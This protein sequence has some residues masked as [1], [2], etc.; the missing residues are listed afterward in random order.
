MD[1][2]RLTPAAVELVVVDP[3]HEHAAWCLARYTEEL[4]RRSA[5]TFDPSTGATALPEEL[6]PPAG[7]FFVAYV[8]GEPVGCGAVKHHRDAP[9]EI[10]RMW[11]AP[12]ARG[13][14]LGRRLLETL[15]RCA[16]EAGASVARI[17]TN[18]DLHEAV[19]LYVTSGWGE[20]APFN[21]EPYAD[22]WMEKQLS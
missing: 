5:R 11:L 18:R 2:R 8:G 14:G 4:N 17:E 15:E 10:K 7:A 6:R 19:A 13:L 9:A 20:V 16:R 1:E 3:E 22:L 21:D 12:G